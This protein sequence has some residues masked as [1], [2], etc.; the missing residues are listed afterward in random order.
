MRSPVAALIAAL[1]AVAMPVMSTLAGG[2]ASPRSTADAVADAGRALHQ[3]RPA[4]PAPAV[5]AEA[6]GISATFWRIEPPTFAEWG[7]TPKDSGEKKPPG[8]KNSGIP[9]AGFTETGLALFGNTKGYRVREDW[10]EMRKAQ[11]PPA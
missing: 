8:I 5:P 7:D 11:G 9:E 2:T 6:S 4:A 1:L 3:D 10:L